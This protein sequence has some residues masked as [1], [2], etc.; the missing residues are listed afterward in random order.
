MM[1]SSGVLLHIATLPGKYGIGQL[2]KEAFAFADFLSR[3]GQS[4]WQVL[5]LVP[6]GYGDSPYQS[7]CSVAGNEY[8][9]D[10][11]DLF[12]RGL[13]KKSE[14]AACVTDMSSR[15]DYHDLYLTRYSVLRK[16]FSR[17]D[18]SDGAFAD[19]VKKG[20]YA[21]YA[22][23]RAIKD[24]HD[25]LP[26]Y[27]WEDP[28]KFRYEDAI[29]GFYAKH[30][31]DILFWQ[32]TQY[33]FSAQWQALRNY[34]HSLGIKIIGDIPIYIAYDSSEC[35]TRPS[36]VKLDPSRRPVTVAGCPPDAFC[37]SGQLWGNP[38]YDWERMKEDGWSW[39]KARMKKVMS[40]C[41]VVRIDHFRG[42]EK[43]YE[44]PYG[45]P[46][47]VNGRWTPGPGAEFFRE[48]ERSLGEMHVIAEDLGALDD[49]A[50]AMFAEVGY[51][52]MKV[53]QFA[54]GSGEDN[55]YLPHNYHDDNCVA[56]TGT[57][58][59]DTLLGFIRS[60]GDGRQVFR[61]ALN[62][63]LGRTELPAAGESD[64]EMCDSVIELCYKSVAKCAI[65]PLQDWLGIGG[66][67]RINVPSVL[68][69]SNW[70]YRIPA[71]YA[72]YELERKMRSLSEKY[73]RTDVKV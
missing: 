62:G 12:A 44:I 5:P 68:S 55:E 35:W 3:A 20:E 63:E 31:D 22:L 28:L 2:G 1:R 60:L 41:D 6:T 45:S 37:E 14:L 51:P 70:S 8:F 56:Y 15:I 66:E 69:A 43:Y 61:E 49:A 46:T 33:M 27:E 54:F 4:Y 9:I 29:A 19:F 38:V 24:E 42:F 23:F 34:V 36:L 72:S 65:I 13:L 64:E 71:D 16:A 50:R 7:F 21:D 32:W 10:L 30:A 59:N 17:F 48:L 11:D 67:G 25:G 52:G 26:W 57:H 73:G 18:R 39:W 47:A 40:L 53:L 58:D